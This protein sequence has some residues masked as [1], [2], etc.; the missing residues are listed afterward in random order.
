MADFSDKLTLLGSQ[1]EAGLS[2]EIKDSLALLRKTYPNANLRC[3]DFDGQVGLVMD[4]DIK[5]PNRAVD[6]RKKEPVIIKI[7]RDH[8]PFVPPSPYTDRLDFPAENTPHINPVKK[9]K[10]YSICLFRGD[11]SDWFAQHTIVDFVERL[12]CWMEDA[13]AGE[14]NKPGDDFEFTR[15]DQDQHAIF[16]PQKDVLDTL[17]K[18]WRE[19][20]GSGGLILSS[21]VQELDTEPHN[22]LKKR[23]SWL[24]NLIDKPIIGILKEDVIRN[25]DQI[26]GIILFAPEDHIDSRYITKLPENVDD[27]IEWADD[28]YID[29]KTCLYRFNNSA[30]KQDAIVPITF[31]IKRP[32]K[33]INHLS[34]IEFIS[35][36]IFPTG[37]QNG[38]EIQSGSLVESAGL[39][40]RNSVALAKYLSGY[41]DSYEYEKIHY[42]GL[43]AVGSKVAL[44]FARSGIV[45]SSLIDPQH[46]L[47]HNNIRNGIINLPGVRKIDKLSMDILNIYPLDTEATGKMRNYPHAVIKVL[48]DEPKLFTDQKALLVDTTGSFGVENLLNSK[49]KDKGSRYSRIE[50]ADRGNLGFL[51]IEG[52]NRNPRMDD[53]MMEVYRSALTDNTISKWLN[54]NKTARESHSLLDEIYL[55]LNCSSDTLVMPDDKVSIHAS[56]ATVGLRSVMHSKMS[57]GYLQITTLSEDNKVQMITEVSQIRPVVVVRCDNQPDWQMRLRSSLREKLIQELDH[58]KPNE[59]G[60]ILI[61]KIDRAKKIIYVTDII[62]APADSK[63]SPYLFTR[64]IEGLK[65]KVEKIRVQTGEMLEYVGEWHTHPTGSAKLSGTDQNA[66]SEIRK[67]LDPLKYPTC[68]TIINGSKIHPYIFTKYE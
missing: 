33:V 1:D 26:A 64:G 32:R 59:T 38:Y 27:L 61:G 50:L 57:D 68:V 45:P 22:P 21:Y 58:N 34:E 44:H 30:L 16:F 67:V 23:C 54:E 39:I 14:L 13:A 48:K 53:L 37:V 9:G 31:A 7:D 49:L 46:S 5:R 40:P 19:N 60:G 15:V 10:P 18:S 12:K 55:G 24:L 43:G 51:R 2:L 8:Y 66:I 56:T 17:R 36:I 25:I 20:N 41:P 62:T 6:F 29:L 47:P 4:I 3:Y 11:S 63:K 52:I 65:E 42:V 35:F 28:R